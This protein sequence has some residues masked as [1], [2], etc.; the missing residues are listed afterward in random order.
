[1]A[2]VAVATPADR[3]TYHPFLNQVLLETFD[4][5]LDQTTLGQARCDATI[6]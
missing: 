1:M 6:E 3:P 4:C 2:V 5:D